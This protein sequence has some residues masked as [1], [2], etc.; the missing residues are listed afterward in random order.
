MIDKVSQ[1]LELP[2]RMFMFLFFGALMLGEYLM[3]KVDMADSFV[4]IM[5]YCFRFGR[6]EAKKEASRK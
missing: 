6:Q 4:V 3:D 2:S 1:H 5:I